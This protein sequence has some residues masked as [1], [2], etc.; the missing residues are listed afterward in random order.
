MHKHY[1]AARLHSLRGAVRRAL[2]FRARERRAA[3]AL[4]GLTAASG[5]GAGPFPA[6]FELSRLLPANGGD[7]SEG[8]VMEGIQST[9]EAGYAVSRAGD[10]NGDGIDDLIVGARRADYGNDDR[11]GQSYVL[12][13]RHSPFAAVFSLTALLPAFG[14]DGSEGFVLNGRDH[15]DS[16]SA[17]AGAGDVNGDGISD[18][19]VGAPI[20]STPRHSSAGQTYVVFGRPDFPALFELQRLVLPDADGTYGFALNGIRDCHNG[21]CDHSGS[22][23]SMAGDVNSDG[24]VD[25]LVGAYGAWPTDDDR[26]AGQAYLVFGPNPGV[27]EFNLGDL[28]PPDGGDGTIGVIFDGIDETDNLGRTVRSAG[29]LN[30][31]GI[32]DFAMAAPRA[33]GNDGETYVIFGRT[34]PY[35]GRFFLADLFPDGG[36]D[37]SEGFVLDNA[38]GNSSGRGIG[39]VG[40]VNG[41]GLSDL[42]ISGS[43]PAG[44]PPLPASFA[45]VI[46]GRAAGFPPVFDLVDLLPDNGGD[47]SAGFALVGNAE[48]FGSTTAARVGD[49]NGDGLNDML[50]GAGY[51]D[52]DGNQNAGR[53]YVLFGNAAGFPPSFVLNEL[54]AANGGDGSKGFVIEGIEGNACTAAGGDVDINADGIDDIVIGARH[55][56]EDSEGA[57]YVVFGRAA[58]PDSDGDGVPDDA[59]NCTEVANAD[60]RDT[61]GDGFGNICDADLD[62]NCLVAGNDWLI[63]RDALGMNDP[64]ADLN[65]DGIVARQDVLILFTSRFQPPGPSGIPNA[66]KT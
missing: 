65:G 49:V 63:M 20:A 28:R 11:V 43:P 62:D 32:D 25:V 53:C 58:A 66:C 5:V 34:A 60:Q 64:H 40:D 45:Y 15:T 30:A 59:D 24:Y 7:G 36:G 22:S 61:N 55:A 27:P 52:P 31:D 54:L 44:Q 39:D 1:M 18:V 51:A 26:S 47:G 8:F 33:D 48:D 4:V 3:W 46:F 21:I 50:I 9:D 57:A 56:G 19:I 6:E 10:V 38:E 2:A 13:G 14:G 42:L 23:V 41:D 35:P 12:F 37:G 29:D 17:V 16:G